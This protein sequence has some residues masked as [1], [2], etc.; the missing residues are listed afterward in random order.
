M[1]EWFR[2]IGDGTFEQ[3]WPLDIQIECSID[4]MQ[5]LIS[6]SLEPTTDNF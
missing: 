5:K 4:E 2:D 6:P 1:V 3:K